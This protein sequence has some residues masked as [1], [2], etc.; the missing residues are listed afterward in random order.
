MPPATNHDSAVLPDL[1]ARMAPHLDTVMERLLQLSEQAESETVRL[2]ALREILDRTYGKP[3][4]KAPITENLNDSL[5]DWSD[6]DL[7]TVA[8]CGAGGASAAGK[9]PL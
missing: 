4:S 8:R 1:A 5:A 6:E 9:R 7:E 2:A 3:T